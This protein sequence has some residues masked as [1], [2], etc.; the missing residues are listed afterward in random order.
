LLVDP[1]SHR[2]YIATKELLGNGKVYE[3][4]ASLSTTDVN[5]LTPV[6]ADPPLTTSADFAP[7]GSRVVVLTYLGAFWSDDV[8]GAWHRFEVPLP[9]Q[10]EAIAYTRDVSSVLVGGEGA[11]ST[12]Y[13]AAA[14]TA[15][16]PTSPVVQSEAPQPPSQSAQA[17]PSRSRPA[18]D[19]DRRTPVQALVALAAVVLLV[20]AILAVRRT[21]RR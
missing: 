5:V 14:P 18:P 11:H 20:V 17:P 13:R 16:A 10:A 2:V 21:R 6:G 8:G 3:A 19:S 9:G 15:A 7:D 4:P 12:V 1:N